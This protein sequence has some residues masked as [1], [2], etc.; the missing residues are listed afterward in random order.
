LGR[1][2]LLIIYNLNIIFIIKFYFQAAQH[3]SI[4]RET[5]FAMKNLKQS[6]PQLNKGEDTLSKPRI[7]TDSCTR[8]N[9][10]PQ[11]ASSK[12]RSIN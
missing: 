10:I 7:L 3:S 1:S 5:H 11:T 4:K 6:D 12:S 2:K 8:K 9:G